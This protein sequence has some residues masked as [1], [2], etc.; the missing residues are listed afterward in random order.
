MKRNQANQSRRDFLFKGAAV[1]GALSL[2]VGLPGGE[3]GAQAGDPEITHWIQIQP[4]D[5]VIIKI[6][7]SELG[8]G[9]FTGLA[10]LVCEEL[11][12]DWSKV[13]PEY[14]DVNEHVR[15]N[16]IYGQMSTGGS[17]ATSALRRV[18]R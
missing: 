3:A 10:Q 15:R 7:R 2:G 6:A 4:D 9:S 12:C 13:R 1:G 5:T 16:R 11:E 8:Q 18:G 14:A 17:R